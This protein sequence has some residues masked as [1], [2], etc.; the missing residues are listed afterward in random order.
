MKQTKLKLK[1]EVSTIFPLTKEELYQELLL[2]ENR[3]N[4]ES[5]LRFHI[6]A[7]KDKDIKK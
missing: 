2:A 1:V 4:T 5:K 7:P 3:M 6:I